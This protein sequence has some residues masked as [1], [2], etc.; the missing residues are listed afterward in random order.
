MM[1][2]KIKRGLSFTIVNQA[3][4]ELDDRLIAQA[5]AAPGQTSAQQ[6]LLMLLQQAQAQQNQPQ[7]T[8]LSSLL[9]P[10]AV[11]QSRLSCQAVLLPPPA[12]S[13]QLV[14]CVWGRPRGHTHTRAGRPS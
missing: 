4:A 3:R 12:P 5:A 2:N 6:Q 1:K 11:S 14:A 13:T 10:P 9:Q 7:P 8:A